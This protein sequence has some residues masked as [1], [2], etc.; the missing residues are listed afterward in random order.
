MA[1][2]TIKFQLSNSTGLKKNI[3]MSGLG[4]DLIIHP[5]ME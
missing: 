1:S 2:L 3:H 5:T 4:Y